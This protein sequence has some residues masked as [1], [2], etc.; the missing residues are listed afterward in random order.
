VDFE[1]LP[2]LDEHAA[3]AATE[4]MP[5][6]PDFLRLTGFQDRPGSRSSTLGRLCFEGKIGG[7]GTTREAL[8]DLA[9]SL[10]RQE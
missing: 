10:L 4:I 7:G 6:A 5:A 3:G 2:G 8:R 9:G 1:E